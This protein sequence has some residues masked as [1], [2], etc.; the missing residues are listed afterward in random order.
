MTIVNSQQGTT[1]TWKA[2]F[3][4]ETSPGQ[5]GAGSTDQPFSMHLTACVSSKLT[6]P[7][8][9]VDSWTIPELDFEACADED[10][11]VGFLSMIQI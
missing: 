3:F 5:A 8:S 11:N 10:G 4:H 2:N 1:P 7:N 9:A 6:L